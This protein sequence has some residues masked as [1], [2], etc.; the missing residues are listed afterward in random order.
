VDEIGEQK[1][2]AQD[3]NPVEGMRQKLVSKIKNN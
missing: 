3:A 1:C 2:P